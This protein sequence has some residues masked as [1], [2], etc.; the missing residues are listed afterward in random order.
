MIQLL[1]N[2]QRNMQPLYMVGLMANQ[3][4]NDFGKPYDADLLLIYEGGQTDISERI[5]SDA[6]SALATLCAR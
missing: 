4:S 1:L 5:R 3:C 6:V 2:R